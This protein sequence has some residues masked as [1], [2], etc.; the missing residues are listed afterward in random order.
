MTTYCLVFYRQL[1]IASY[2]WGEDVEVETVLLPR[3]WTVVSLHHLQGHDL[4]T[5]HQR[6][7][8][9]EFSLS[10]PF[11]RQW[12]L[13]GKSLS[14]FNV[15]EVCQLLYT[16]SLSFVLHLKSVNCITLEFCLL[17]YTWRLSIALYLKSVNCIILEVCQLYYTWSM[18]NV[19]YLNVLYL[20]SVK[21]IILEVCQLYFTWTC[22]FIVLYL[23]SVNYVIDSQ[24]YYL[25]T[26]FIIHLINQRYSIALTK[27]LSK[28][29]PWKMSFPTGGSAKGIPLKEK[30]SLP[31]T[32][33]STNPFTAPNFVLTS[34][35]LAYPLVAVSK[36]IEH[37]SA[38]IVTCF[39][40]PI[41]VKLFRLPEKWKVE[42]D[43]LEL[44]FIS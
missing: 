34:A 13:F 31:S 11:K 21:C 2:L 6:L 38:S 8:G 41:L 25:V 39:R 3:E 18:S 42:L 27:N 23:K 26:L 44:K 33:L 10:C 40:M 20:K 37:N 28:T 14:M 36:T 35:C 30:N 12:V 7:T 22:Q 32:A 24:L 4:G 16:W 17:Y 19:L 5:W 9:I 29:S 15:L 43:W 1:L